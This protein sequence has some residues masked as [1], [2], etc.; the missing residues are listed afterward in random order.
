LARHV[1]HDRLGDEERRAVHIKIGIVVGGH[2]V[3]KRL[4]KKRTRRVDQL[5]DMAPLGVDARNQGRERRSVG[6]IS[7]N[8]FNGP[9]LLAQLSLGRR[10]LRLVPS[11]QQH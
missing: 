7:D 1:A 2:V 6:E 3:Q 8:R 11:H 4:R 5:V 9:A 10:Q